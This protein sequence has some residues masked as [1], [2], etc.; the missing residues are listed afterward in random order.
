M[1]DLGLTHIALEV[2][3]VD[4]SI[5][6]YTKYADMRVINRR[7]D[8]MTQVDVALISDLTRHDRHCVT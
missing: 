2:S 1:P 5:S 6:F 8:Q 7:V 4:A 3:D